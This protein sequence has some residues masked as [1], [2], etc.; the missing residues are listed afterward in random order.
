MGS[1]V[2]FPHSPLQAFTHSLQPTPTTLASL[3]QALAPG[4]PRLLTPL[5]IPRGENITVLVEDDQGNEVP[6]Q[7]GVNIALLSSGSGLLVRVPTWL[8]MNEGDSV[9]VFW[10]D[11]NLP[12]VSKTLGPGEPNNEV[13]L[14]VPPAAIQNGQA[15]VFHR[16]IRTDGGLPD[17]SNPIQVL[18]KLTL[19]GGYDPE[20][21]QPGHQNLLAPIVPVDKVLPEH[22][23][24]GLNVTLARYLNIRIRDTI[25]L[26]WGG[27]TVTYTL[28]KND[29]DNGAPIT[30]HVPGR[31]IEQAGDSLRLE[32]I[33]KVIDEVQNQSIDGNGLPW[34]V[35]RYVEVEVG[36]D[37]LDAPYSEEFYEEVIDLDLLG[38]RN[39]DIAIYLTPGQFTPGDS[40]T[41]AWAG[42]TADDAPVE[43]DRTQAVPAGRVMH[44]IIENAEARKLPNGRV[45]LS[46]TRSK[47]SDGSVNRSRSATWRIVGQV[48]ELPAPSVLEARGGTLDPALPY[49]TVQIPPWLGMYAGQPLSM[50]WTGTTEGGSL[51]YFEESTPVLG[52]EVD[53]L[54]NRLTLAKDI[55]PLGGSTV[56]VY[57][58]ATINGTVRQ[59]DTLTL[60]VGIAAGT[61][62]APG[63]DEAVDGYL[64]P[65]TL[66]GNRATLR[67][68]HDGVIRA[69][70]TLTFY[71]TGSNT[72][73]YSDYTVANSGTSTPFYIPI[74]QISP[75]LNGQ[76]TALYRVERA[77][78]IIGT[79]REL[80]LPIG[81]GAIVLPPPSV[82]LATNGVLDPVLA[83]QQPVVAQVDFADMQL[84]DE[85]SIAVFTR[86]NV[87]A[88]QSPA[89][90]GSPFKSLSFTIPVEVI[91]KNLDS[92]LYFYSAMVRNSVPTLS[93]AYTLT[94]LAFEQSDLP[95]PEVPQADINDVLDLGS[96]IGDA[97]V[98]VAAWPLIAVGQRV[99]LRAIGTR[100]N[101][102]PT[103]ISLLIASPVDLNQANNGL[104]VI[105][106]RTQLDLLKHHS[107]LTVELLVNFEGTS[108]EA[109]A[110]TFPERALTMAVIAIVTPSI[111]SVHDGAQE[112]ANGG[113]TTSTSLTLSGSA[114]NSQRVEIFDGT[115]SKGI[116]TVNASGIWT[117]PVSGLSVAA[118]SFT[119]KGLYGNNPTSPARTLNVVAT[120]TPSISSVKD[121]ANVEIPNAGFTTST[122]VTLSGKASNNQ[123]VEIFDGTTSKGTAGAN[124]SGDWVLQV[125]GLAVAAHSFTAKGLYGNNPTSPARTFSV[126]DLV[127]AP[128]VMSLTGK[129]IRNTSWD[130]KRTGQEYI[131]N[132]DTR[133]ASGGITPYGY[134]S[135]NPAIAA[136]NASS[137]RVIGMRNGTATI[138]VTDRNGA[139]ASY[140][141]TVSNVWQLYVNY[142]LIPYQ[143]M[144]ATVANLGG[145]PVSQA[146]ISLLL[147]YYTYPHP[148]QSA[149]DWYWLG[150][151]GNC[152]GAS[153]IAYNYL[154]EQQRCWSMNQSFPMYCLVP[155]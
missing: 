57:Y 83:N 52:S 40:L 17:E 39:L 33:Y 92:E 12:A 134:T 97:Q 117:L 7:A 149:S 86:A 65:D 102:V 127:I 26:S 98:T 82:P 145:Q 59:S 62:T 23:V 99:W 15:S 94:V 66:V 74:A 152:D 42:R 44:F 129:A 20:A 124:A 1:P 154:S 45:R 70:D 114:S 118:H 73:L 75:N 35:A 138:T 36:Q 25:T 144:L 88:Y 80:V 69:G 21:G 60:N 121:A 29:I 55:L 63:V 5:G 71:W 14:L 135:S 139:Q 47:A 81:S 90:P 72:P 58:L 125:T 16:V 49:A 77:G 54:V 18:V 150:Y 61:L 37:L 76:V 132:Y 122:T 43:F 50:I 120:L 155:S 111:S 89:T 96:F 126:V 13:F 79:S 146:D 106:P 8:T 34:S 3:P 119:A 148:H 137:G 116:A 123:Q 87:L 78:V 22:V 151:H 46:Y 105:L 142:S 32:V 9:Y 133:A 64:N 109:L 128:G 11:S 100:S 85:Y 67:I 108:N 140:T 136:V 48:L 104:N 153:G 30:V 131:G 51:V 101:D 28:T 38:A 91:A 141:I 93:Q 143:S 19:P 6:G 10:N 112:V 4:A 2:P 68:D 107:T 56:Q 103:T 130:Y 147:R 113:T 110:V 27:V 95:I 53:T 115:V 31:V 84:Q 41:L 24:S